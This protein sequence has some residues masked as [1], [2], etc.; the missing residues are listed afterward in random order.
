MIPDDVRKSEM[1]NAQKRLLRSKAEDKKKIAHE[2][3]QTGDYSGAKLDLM[4][5][6]HLI[7]EALQ[8]V[9]A[10]GERGS[11]ERTIQDDIETL[12]RKILSEEK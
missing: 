8:K 12:W 7:H 4:D 10:L 3:F 1:L 6:R 9:R 11:S 2:K 5:A